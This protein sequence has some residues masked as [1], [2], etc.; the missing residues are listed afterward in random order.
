MPLVWA[1]SEYI[2]LPRQRV[3]RYLNQKKTA[4]LQIWTASMP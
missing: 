2:K 3:E 4:N 1:H